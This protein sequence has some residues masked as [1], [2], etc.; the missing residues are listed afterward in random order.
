MSQI[1][2]PDDFLVHGMRLD[3]YGSGWTEGDLC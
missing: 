2:D 3:P 1:L